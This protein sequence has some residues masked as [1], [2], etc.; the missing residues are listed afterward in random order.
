LRKRAQDTQ[1][2]SHLILHGSVPEYQLRVLYRRAIALVF[3]STGEGFGYPI[4]EALHEGCPAICLTHG[5]GPEIVGTLLQTCSS[6]IAELAAL[7]NEYAVMPEQERACLAARLRVRASEF[8]IGAMAEKTFRVLTAGI[9]GNTSED[10][11]DYVASQDHCSH[12]V[13]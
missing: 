8:S 4:L 7:M 12:T 6:A 2:L 11:S 3:P 9:R 13:V 10:I 1:I 5:P